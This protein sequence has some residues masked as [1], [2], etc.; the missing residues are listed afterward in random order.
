[1]IQTLQA[2]SAW[3]ALALTGK[4]WQGN[5]RSGITSWTR[6]GYTVNMSF[7]SSVSSYSKRNSQEQFNLTVFTRWCRTLYK[8]CGNILLRCRSIIGTSDTD[9]TKNRMQSL[10]RG[11]NWPTTTTTSGRCESVNIRELSRINRLPWH[12]MNIKLMKNLLSAV[13]SDRCGLH[14]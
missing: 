1:M 12:D 2:C 13:L 5:T 11:L 4:G 6:F 3:H 14:A 10:L 9:S 7:V 8:A